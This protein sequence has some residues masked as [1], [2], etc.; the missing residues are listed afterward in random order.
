MTPPSNPASNLSESINR[1]LNAYALAAGSAGVG[2]LA[3]AQPAAARI[4]YTAAHIPIVQNGGLVGLD[5]NHDGINDF[6]FSNTYYVEAG[7]RRPEGFEQFALMVEPVQKPNQVLSFESGRTVCAAHLL[8]GK[9]VGP[10]GPFQPGHSFLPMDQG[11][12]D[13]T[14]FNAFG[15]WLKAKQGYLGLKFVIKGK[16]HFGWAHIQIAGESNPTITGYAYETIPNK[17][18]LTGQTKQLEDLGADQPVSLSAPPTQPATLGLLA[19]GSRG[20]S[21]WRRD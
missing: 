9:T 14:S 8:K 21:I 13:F 5:L 6:Q 2:L 18:I 1:R 7:Q 3:S 15:P 16:I 17:A 11:A 4:V 12:G 20:L 10:H 19:M